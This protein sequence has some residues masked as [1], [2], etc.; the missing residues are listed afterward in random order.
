MNKNIPVLEME[1]HL[2]TGRIKQITKYLNIEYMPIVTIYASDKE[3]ALQSWMQYRSIPE[4]RHD[5]KD[6]LLDYGIETAD[7][8]SLKNLGLNLTDQY[9]F[10]PCHVDLAWEKVNL[11]QNHFE[12]GLSNSLENNSLSPDASSNGELKKMWIIK[13]GERHLL[14]AGTAP[15][16][17]QAYNEVVAA[18]LLTDANIKHIDYTLETYNNEVYSS[19]KTFVDI[20]TEYIPALH[21]LNVRKKLNHENHYTHFQKCA[22]E[23]RIPFSDEYMKTMLAFD[24]LINNA[25]RH[26]GNFGFIRNVETLEF[27]GFAPIFDNGNSLWYTDLTK[28]IKLSKQPSKP[29]APLH[30]KQLKLIDKINNIDLSMFHKQ[31]VLNIL[32]NTFKKSDYLDE[33]RI[34]KIAY[35]V[36]KRYLELSA[37]LTKSVYR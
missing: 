35:M 28:N 37:H 5:L 7:A 20:N 14:K 3:S 4:A 26:Y 19:C 24:F 33:E 25:D 11:F 12:V 32:N 1:I 23:L 34:E 27:Q 22:E 29:F 6:I 2:Q 36:D 10:K 15:Y 17:Q 21:I 16:Y 31:N 18:K 8:L 13:N 9:W 30:E